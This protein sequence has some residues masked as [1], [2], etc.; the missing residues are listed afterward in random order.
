M[1][2][3]LGN[4]DM[5]LE[6][7]AP[8]PAADELTLLSEVMP[9]SGGRVLE[10]G[11]GAAEKSRLLAKAYPDLELVATEVDAAQHAKNKA[12]DKPANLSFE[13]A[14]AQAL[15]LGDASFDLVLMFKSLHHVPTDLIPQALAEIR[16]VL[17]QGGLAW[18]S[19]PVFAGE[20]NEIMRLFH[21]E[22]QVRLAAFDGVKQ[23]VEA[24]LFRCE[25]QI[26]F[27]DPR[28]FP[29]FESFE[30]RVI[31]VTYADHQLSPDV[32]TEVRRRFERRLS[33]DGARFVS[34]MR[35]DLLR[36]A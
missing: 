11:C 19:E 14:G 32:E 8:A 17:K 2:S 12:A 16:R 22:Q 3:R 7:N 1:T 34:P 9:G 31:R 6:A 26:F 10:L 36:A 29:D 23:V 20:L 4:I 28:Q 24:G 35:V 5:K 25:K 13:A 15:P 21:D 27:G 33:A 30:E 18:I